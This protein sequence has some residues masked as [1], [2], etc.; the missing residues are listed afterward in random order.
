MN[1]NNAII[2]TP[3]ADLKVVVPGA[4]FGAVGTCGQRCTST[5]RLIIHESVYDKVRDAIVGAYGQLTIGNPLDETNHIGPLIDHDAVNTYLAAIEKAKAEGGNVLVKGGVL[6]GEGYESGCYVKPA[7]IE[8]E[9]HFK[10]VQHETFAPILYLIKYS[11]DVENAIEK[12][13]GVAQGLSSA[14]M[15]NE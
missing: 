4:V 14:I 8:V 11:G 15:T 13:N 2:I 12:Q 7:I 5:R 6:E 1:S 9:N 3:T 10:I